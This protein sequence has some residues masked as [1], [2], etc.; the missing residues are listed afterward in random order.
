MNNT[1]TNNKPSIANYDIRRYDKRAVIAA[2]TE[3]V[4]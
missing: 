1:I 2:N 3:E 4:F